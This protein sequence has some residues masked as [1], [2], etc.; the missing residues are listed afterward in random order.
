MVD[1][2]ECVAPKD[3]GWNYAPY[4]FYLLSILFPSGPSPGTSLVNIASKVGM[5]LY[6]GLPG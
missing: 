6:V 1:V 2:N 3:A 4:V 5:D